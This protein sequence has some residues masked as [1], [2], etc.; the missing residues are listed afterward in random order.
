MQPHERLPL[1]GSLR[2][3]EEDCVSMNKDVPHQIAGDM[4]SLN[5]AEA[6]ARDLLK[7]ARAQGL[8]VGQ[9]YTSLD[10]DIAQWLGR[11]R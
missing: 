1:T 6:Q 5:L 8:S 11:L 10:E 2:H 7:T 9:T 4:A 3:L